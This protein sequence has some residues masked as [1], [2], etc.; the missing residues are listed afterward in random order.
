MGETL[1]LLRIFFGYKSV[2]MA[3]KLNISQSFLSEVENNK[4][5]ATLEL[6]NQYSKVLNI[7]VSTIV[8]LAES[9]ENDKSSKKDIKHNLAG[10]GIKVLKILKENGELDD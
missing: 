3:K 5:N 9:L 2:E 7:K 1:K 8:L 6:L 4:K 10:I